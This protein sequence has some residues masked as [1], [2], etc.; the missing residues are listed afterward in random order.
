MD[1][2]GNA[3]HG[4]QRRLGAD[5]AAPAAR[6]RTAS[7]VHPIKADALKPVVDKFK[8][9]GQ[10]VQ[11]W[12]WSSRSRR[13]TTS[14]ATGSPPA[15][16]IPGFYSPADVT[17]QIERRRAALGDAAAADAGDAGGRHDQ[18]LLR[19][20]A[21]EPAGGR[22][23]A[24]ACRSS[25]TTRSGR[26]IPRRC[27]ASPRRGPTRIRTRTSRVIKALIRAAHVARRERRRQPHRGASKILAKPEYVGADDGG[28]RQQHDR[29]VRVREGRQARRCPTSTCSSATT[30][31]I[32]T[33]RDAV[34]YL[35]QMRRWGQI[36]EGKPDAWYVE[37]AKQVY[38]PDI[39]LQAAQAA[40]RRRQ[41]QGGRLPVGQRRLQARRRTEFIDG[42]DLRRPQAERLHRQARRSASRAAEVEGGN[43]VGK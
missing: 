32:R 17:G 40:G 19:R 10:A 43:V 38:R 28:D 33:T 36:A 24:S 35:T 6:T 3:H 42:V 5:E 23:R 27:S 37:T 34:W 15:A 22:S 39:Y 31:P 21:V 25:P 16:S 18:R 1:L 12:A 41:G 8:A 4:L 7:R 2:N 29:H 26:T 13:T 9:D 20:R 30:P 11:A 14:C